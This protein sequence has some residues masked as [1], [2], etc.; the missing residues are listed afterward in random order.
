MVNS[1]A[2][3]KSVFFILSLLLVSCQNNE[4]TVELSSPDSSYNFNLTT[5]GVLSYSVSWNEVVIIDNSVL[6]FKLADGSI[7]PG[8]IKV[9]E[10]VNKSVDEEWKPVYGENSN[11][12]DKYNEALVSFK[13]SNTIMPSTCPVSLIQLVWY[14]L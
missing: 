2:I 14:L 3:C 8:E 11:Y 10:I 7:I 13:G 1:K 4:K 6:G 12:S 5:E 9:T